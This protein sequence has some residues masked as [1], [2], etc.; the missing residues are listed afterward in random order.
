MFLSIDGTEQIQV[1]QGRGSIVD[2]PHVTVDS[3]IGIFVINV[4]ILNSQDKIN[5]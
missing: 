4:R 5:D 1:P 3:K 2:E